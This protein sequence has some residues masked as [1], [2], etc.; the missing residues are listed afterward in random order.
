LITEVASN[1]GL[2][3]AIA[4]NQV[5]QDA[6]TTALNDDKDFHNIV[7]RVTIDNLT[8]A[9]NAQQK[10]TLQ[11]EKNYWMMSMKQILFQMVRP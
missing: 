9:N 7:K 5:L 4:G 6:V 2:Q 1:E 10:F 8:N 3:E 11:K